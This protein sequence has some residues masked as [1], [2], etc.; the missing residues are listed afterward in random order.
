MQ[1]KEAAGTL[2]QPTTVRVG[3]RHGPNVMG[4]HGGARMIRVVAR[5]KKNG[6]GLSADH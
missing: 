3:G 5:H 1:C 2:H 4:I 6:A